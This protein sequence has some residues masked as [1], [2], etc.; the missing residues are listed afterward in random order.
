[1]PRMRLLGPD[2]LV[3]LLLD[4]YAHL[5]DEAKKQLPLRRVWMPDPQ[6]AEE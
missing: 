5:P 3:E 2:D 1:M 6:T 4:H